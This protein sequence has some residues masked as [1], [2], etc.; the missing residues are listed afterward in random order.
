MIVLNVRCG[1]DELVKNLLK[2]IAL[3]GTIISENCGGVAFGEF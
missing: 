2:M 1:A 3:L